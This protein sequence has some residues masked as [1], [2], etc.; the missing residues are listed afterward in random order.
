MAASWWCG[1]QL[2]G[3]DGGARTGSGASSAVR[4][5]PPHAARR[6]IRGEQPQGPAAGDHA[7]G[8]R[9]L[10]LAAPTASAAAAAPP[11]S[12]LPGG[13]DDHD[14]SAH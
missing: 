1:G 14:A 6:P 9:E 7:E 10:S 12:M 8:W 13:G 11:G 5:K 3:T 4:R 2:A